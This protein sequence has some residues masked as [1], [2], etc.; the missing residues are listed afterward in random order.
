MQQMTNSFT[1]NAN[2][3]R[4]CTIEATQMWYYKLK[5]MENDGYEAVQLGFQDLREVSTTN[6]AKGQVAKCHS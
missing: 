5:P 6:L 1:R 2:G 4:N 3:T